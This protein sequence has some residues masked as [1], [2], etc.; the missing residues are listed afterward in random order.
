M[1]SNPN[2]QP[3][4][5][6]QD[7]L[8]AVGQP[9]N[10]A[11]VYPGWIDRRAQATLIE[12][13]Q[14][15]VRQAPFMA[16]VTPGGRQMSVRMTAA[17]RLGWITDRGGYRYEA[18]H[19]NGSPWPPI[20]EPA[21]EIWRALSG[22][23]EL[24]D[25]CLINFYGPGARMGLHQ[26]RDEGDFSFPVLSISLGDAGLFRIGGPDRRDPTRSLWL[27]SGDVLVMAGGA[28]LAWHGIDRIRHGSCTLLPHGGRI[29]L[30]LRVVRDAN[31]RD[32][33]SR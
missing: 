27:H 15:V 22:T 20:P 31:R 10:G 14:A 1:K 9:L 3:E 18:R 23:K 33:A 8:P 5:P 16:P 21:L 26:D 12:A 7:V 2:D 6:P 30:T 29:N 11:Q 24:P 19:P 17:G 25:C 32:S 4:G 28:R 13:L